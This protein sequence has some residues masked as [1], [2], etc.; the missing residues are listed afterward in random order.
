MK[1]KKR[2]II[3]II[4][5]LVLVILLGGYFYFKNNGLRDSTPANMEFVINDTLENGNGEK[6]KVFL[7]A[8]QSNASGVSHTSELK[9]NISEDKFLEYESGYSNVFINYYNDNGNNFSSGFT[10]VKINQGCSKDT[11][12]PELGMG[13]KLA[14]LYPNEKIFIIKYAWGGSNLYEQWNSKI[15][16]IYKAFIKFTK[17]SMDYLHSKNYNAE[18]VSM[19][20]MQGESDANYAYAWKY[21]SNLS[22]LI[23]SV[24]DDLS[25][26]ICSNGMYFV[27]AYISNSTYWGRYE[28]INAAKKSVCDSNELNLC[29][30]TISEGL[31]YDNEPIGGPDLAHYDSLSEIKLG[32]LFVET[33]ARV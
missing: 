8:G 32:Y 5:V 26:Y 9:K 1:L 21:E 31:T 22:R 14:E 18:I 3:L 12:G 29:I 23:K 27:D 20:W 7:L 15:G 24:R 11:F 4:A 6:V 13:E 33:F 16:N 25:N 19:M 30:D 2:Y 17:E 10:N 28:K